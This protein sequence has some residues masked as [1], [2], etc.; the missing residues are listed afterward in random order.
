MS[1]IEADA[2]QNLPAQQLQDPSFALMRMIERAAMDPNFDV[3]KLDKLLDIKER[4]DREEAR[5]AF[6][7]AM[8]EFKKNPPQIIKDARVYFSTAKGATDYKHAS[9]GAVC[10]A[11]IEGLAKVGISH[12]WEPEQR[13]GLVH[14]TCVLTHERGHSTRTMLFCPPDDSGNK[15]SIQMVSSATTYLSRYTLL[16]ATGLGT[17]DDD[18]GRAT[19]APQGNSER[20]HGPQFITDHQAADLD[21]MI[22][23]IG[24]NKAQFLRFMKVDELAQIQASRMQL[25]VQQLNDIR[26]GI[27]DRKERE[28][29]GA[30]R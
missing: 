24:T 27:N 20:K 3:A 23:E 5:K 18:D 9:L 17:K 21:A 28:A 29:K 10:D 13:E 25:A 4:W 8:A 12:S 30:K 19:G 26:R 14:V 2:V 6:T 16:L 22:S 7:A 15:N 1:V 11:V